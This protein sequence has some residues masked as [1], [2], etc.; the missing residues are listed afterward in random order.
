MICNVTIDI[1]CTNSLIHSHSF[2]LFI[3]SWIG[4]LLA[5]FIKSGGFLILLLVLGN[6]LIHL[7]VCHLADL[8]D[9]RFEEFWENVLG[10]VRIIWISTQPTSLLKRH[11]SFADEEEINTVAAYID[12]KANFLD[13]VLFLKQVGVNLCNAASNEK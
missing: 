6:D 10:E 2:S 3:G 12:Q 11:V 4:L 5:I 7:L 1:H 8:V 13:G 9:G